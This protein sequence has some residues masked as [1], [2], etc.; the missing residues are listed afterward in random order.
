MAEASNGPSRP[1]AVNLER[2]TPS[3]GLDTAKQLFGILDVVDDHGAL[4]RAL[5]DPSR[6]AEDRVKLVHR[7]FVGSTNNS[8]VEAVSGF[9]QRLFTDRSGNDA[10]D[11]VSEL[12]QQRSAEE[13]QLGDGIERAAVI[14][15][16]ASAENRGGLAAMESL[17]DELLRFKNLVDHS[18]DVQGAFAD[19]RASAEAKARLASR[20]MPGASEEGALLIQRAMSKPRGALPGRLIE[21][22]ADVVADRQQRWIA[23][24]AT[25]RPL[26]HEQLEKLR[27]RLN[28]MY[29]RDLKLAVEVDRSLIGGLRV[30]VGEE[31]IDGSMTHRLDQLQ[32]RIGA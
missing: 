1:L 5:T 32:Q 21:R 4:R 15:A 19:S 31:I 11:I 14:M 2:W 26:G 20:L 9:V 27:R 16:A 30:Q 22:F 23:H 17:V 6:P 28:T 13:R 18:E 29:G 3:A 7:L 12:V 25:S 8:T 24:V 10:I